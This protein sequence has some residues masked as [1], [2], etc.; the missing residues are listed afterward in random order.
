MLNEGKKKAWSKIAEECVKAYNK[1]VHTVTGFS[2]AYL[3]NGESTDLLPPELKIINNYSKNLE[4]DR[5][6]A[7]FRSKKITRIQ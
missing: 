1:T 5:K 6:V 2:S 4:Q 3:M 7:L